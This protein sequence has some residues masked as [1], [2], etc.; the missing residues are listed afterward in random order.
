MRESFRA[1]PGTS[2]PR[3]IRVSAGRALVEVGH[4]EVAAARGL[5][6]GT[7]RLPSGELRLAT[8]R[9]WG[10]LRKGKLWLSD[11]HPGASE[12]KGRG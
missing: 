8:R 7:I 5:W 11:A 3:V 12:E 2:V 10:T 9:T 6:N 4:R 1:V